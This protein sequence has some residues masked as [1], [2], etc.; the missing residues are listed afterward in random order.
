MRLVP[1]GLMADRLAGREN[2]GNFVILKVFYRLN[3]LD[4]YFVSITAMLLIVLEVHFSQLL[5]N[6]LYFRACFEVHK[7]HLL[8]FHLDPYY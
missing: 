2:T 4:S 7:I 8:Y 6:E 1:V 5:L 3:Y